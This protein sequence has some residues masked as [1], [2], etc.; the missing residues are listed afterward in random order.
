MHPAINFLPWRLRRTQNRPAV[1]VTA[2]DL[3]PPYL[4]SKGRPAAPVGHA[5]PAG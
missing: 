4:V 1:V 2:H 5:P 3:L